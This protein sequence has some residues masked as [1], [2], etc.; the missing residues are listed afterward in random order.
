VSRT[1]ATASTAVA[2][3]TL[4]AQLLRPT[5]LEASALRKASIVATL[6]PSAPGIAASARLVTLERFDGVEW[7]PVAGAQ[8]GIAGQATWTLKLK[9]GTVELR[10]RWAGSGDLLGAVSTPVHLRV[11]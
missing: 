5:Q 11:F 6:H 9:P 3:L 8:T 7:K 1:T 4:N 2:S 10:A